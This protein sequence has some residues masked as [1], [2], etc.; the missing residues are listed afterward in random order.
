MSFYKVMSKEPGGEFKNLLGKEVLLSTPTDAICFYRAILEERG[1]TK[2]YLDSLQYECAGE[3]RLTYEEAIELYRKLWNHIYGHLIETGKAE[4]IPGYYKHTVLDRWGYKLLND[5]PL[6]Q[7][8]IVKS[9][10]D[11]GNMCKFCPI[12][13][14][15]GINSFQCEGNESVNGLFG[16]YKDTYSWQGQASLAKQIADLSVREVQ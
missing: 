13:W 5:C 9:N 2:E 7:Y 12:D 14:G 8:A 16:L 11:Y 1:E 3:Q 4:E 10:Y 15:N 6:C